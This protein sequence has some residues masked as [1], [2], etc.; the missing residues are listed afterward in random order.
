MERRIA[1]SEPGRGEAAVLAEWNMATRSGH[2]DRI[3]DLL[4]PEREALDYHLADATFERAI[5]LALDPATSEIPVIF[6]TDSRT[7]EKGLWRSTS[8]IRP[9]CAGVIQRPRPRRKTS[10]TCRRRIAT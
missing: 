7:P 1:A 5:E 9:R 6:I 2:A 10:S 8:A 3:R 4:D